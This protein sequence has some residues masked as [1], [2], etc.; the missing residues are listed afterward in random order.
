[1][2]KTKL[3]R[4]PLR[5][6]QWTDVIADVDFLLENGYERAG[7]LSLG[8]ICNHLAIVLECAVDGFPT[9]WPRPVQKL[10][11]MLLLKSMLRHKP[12]NLR[13]PAPPFARQ[14]QPVDD[15]VGA[16]RLKAAIDRFAQPDAQYVPH[17]VFGKLTRDEWKHQQ[18]WHC[19]H[20]LSFLIPSG[21]KHADDGKHTTSAV[22]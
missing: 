18:L 22:S 17:L 2:S 21:K 10:M 12:T 15:E 4:R 9:Q 5:F 19:E 1:M 8:Q 7:Q 11:K 13:A 3:N 16:R 14:T 6:E 20:H